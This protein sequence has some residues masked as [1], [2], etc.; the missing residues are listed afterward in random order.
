MFIGILVIVIGYY[1]Y[2]QQQ[3]HTSGLT[4]DNDA[5]EILKMRYVNGEIDEETYQKMKM[6]LNL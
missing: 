6:N 5:L 1:L 4:K 2:T 3:G